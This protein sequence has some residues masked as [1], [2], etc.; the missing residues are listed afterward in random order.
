MAIKWKGASWPVEVLLRVR[1]RYNRSEFPLLP[2]LLFLHTSPMPAGVLFRLFN[3]VLHALVVIS[4][5]VLPAMAAEIL[6][7]GHKPLPVGVHVLTGGK[8]VIKPGEVL[9][10]CTVVIRDGFIAAVGSK[11]DAPAAARVWDMSGLTIY[12]GLIDCYLTLDS[13]NAPVSTTRT[14]PIADQDRSLTSGSLN[15]FGVPGEE[16]DPGARGPG[17][18]LDVVRSQNRAAESYTPNVRTLETLHELG[19]TSANI[20]PGGGLFRGSTAVLNL[21]PANPNEALVRPDVF[22]SLAFAIDD[23]CEGAYPRSR[24]GGIAAVRQ[25]VYDADHYARDHEHYARHPQ[26]RK[27]PAHNPALEALRSTISTNGS[28]SAAVFEPGSVVM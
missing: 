6:P 22:Q 7:P 10:P 20:V 18:Q 5:A 14:E 1:V 23:A 12:P 8:V 13:S 9:Q 25:V 26:G 19:F 24:M 21:S 27:R 17:Y 3:R 4:I 11:V 16:M 28:R 15:Y 2:A